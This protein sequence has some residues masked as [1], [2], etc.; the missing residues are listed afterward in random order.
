MS[1]LINHLPDERQECEA[2]VLRKCSRTFTRGLWLAAPKVERTVR[3]IEIGDFLTIP[4]MI[5][6]NETLSVAEEVPPISH[7]NQI[8]KHKSGDKLPYKICP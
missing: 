5:V 6:L 3:M 7:A 8:Y 2:S 1:T 4:G